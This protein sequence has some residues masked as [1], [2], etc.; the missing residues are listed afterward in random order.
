MH[1]YITVSLHP[2]MICILIFL[3]LSESAELMLELGDRI[4]HDKCFDRMPSLK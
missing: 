2:Y 1:R 4:E 3:N